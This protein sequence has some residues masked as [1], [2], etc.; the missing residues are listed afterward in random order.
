M[1][2]SWLL[3]SKLNKKLLLF[4]T[5]SKKHIY[6]LF[7]R[8]WPRNCAKGS[9]TVVH[10]RVLSPSQLQ[11]TISGKAVNSGIPLMNRRSELPSDLISANIFWLKD[12][13]SSSREEQ[14]RKI[15]PKHTYRKVFCWLFLYQK[16][17]GPVWPETSNVTWTSKTSA[18]TSWVSGLC[19]VWAHE[20]YA[21]G[22]E[23]STLPAELQHKDMETY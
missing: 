15:K 18:S 8:K 17:L 2:T 4:E 7:F 23:A 13:S 12:L 3:S 10:H 6:E 11:L 20:V 14:R 21:H 19:E 1:V 5:K 22:C 9:L 16:G